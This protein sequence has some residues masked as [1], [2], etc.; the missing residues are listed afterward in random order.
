MRTLLLALGALL[1]VSGCI[2][3]EDNPTTVHDLRVLGVSLEPPELMMRPEQCLAPE[4]ADFFVFLQEVE[5]R[6]LIVDP[7]GQGRTLDYQLWACAD[8]A[9]RDCEVAEQRV[10]LAEG[11]TLE[12]ELVLNIRPAATQLPDG[13]PLVQVA[14]AH[15]QFGGA[16][17]LWLPLVLQL[18]AG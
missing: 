6:A 9:D 15:A 13:T 1:G 5:Y 2:G 10:L 11:T 4:P 14:A 16:F 17:G 18:R 8:V 12:G 3:P 7:A